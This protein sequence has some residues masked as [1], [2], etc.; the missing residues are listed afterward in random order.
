MYLSLF[1]KRE[2]L[3]IKERAFSNF[4]KTSPEPLI[5]AKN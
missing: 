1:N 3:V 4:P 5:G 2:V